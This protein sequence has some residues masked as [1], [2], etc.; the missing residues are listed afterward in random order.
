MWLHPHAD[1][2]S[3]ATVFYVGTARMS[4]LKEKEGSSLGKWTLDSHHN[5]QRRT[6]ESKNA[7]D[8]HQ[9]HWLGSPPLRKKQKTL[10]TGT[11][12]LKHLRHDSGGMEKE[13]ATELD[14]N[15][16]FPTER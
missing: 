11:A 13:E 9:C 7:A 6:P 12:Q 3:C 1:V 2:V 10:T 15:L 4:H 14:Q 16:K 5:S 8:S